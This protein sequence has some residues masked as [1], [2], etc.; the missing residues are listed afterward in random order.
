MKY[1]SVTIFSKRIA[2]YSTKKFKFLLGGLTYF[3]KFYKLLLQSNK[4]KNCRFWKFSDL[5]TKNIFKI[6]K[7]EFFL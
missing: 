4:Q 2:Y 6:L 5:W 1:K 3:Q 7:E